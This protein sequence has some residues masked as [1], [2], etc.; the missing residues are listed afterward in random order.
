MLMSISGIY[1]TTVVVIDGV[2]STGSTSIEV[3]TYTIKD[4][5][6]VEYEGEGKKYMPGDVISFIPKITNKEEESYIRIKIEYVSDEV[7]PMDYITGMPEGWEK[8]GEYYYYKE[9]VAKDEVIKVFETLKIPEYVERMTNE[10]EIQLEIKADAVQ[11]KHFTPDYTEEDPWQGITPERS[12]EIEYGITS[13]QSKITVTLEGDTEN[14][15]SVPSDFL[16]NMERAMPGDSYTSSIEINN[17]DKKKAKYYME[18]DT[19]TDLFDQLDLTI[20]DESGRTI[21]QGKMTKNSKMFLGEYILNES[22]KLNYT[23]KIPKNLTNRYANIVP[24]VNFIFTEEHDEKDKIVEENNGT[25]EERK[26]GEN[27][28]KNPKTGDKI[29]LAIIV[30]LISTVG[31]VTVMLIDY[32]R[33]KE[34]L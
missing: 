32:K 19:D 30:F 17:R 16:K 7:E 22:K 26:T 27:K 10:K 8:H 3:K 13:N 15:V 25:T 31:L 20:T 2:I 33:K 6:E 34:N 9:P 12:T 23:V 29:S 28:T 5:S 21:Y 18:I 14:D 11:A 4:G 1:A 24:N